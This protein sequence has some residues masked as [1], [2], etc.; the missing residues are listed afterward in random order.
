VSYI[1][2][3]TCT[4]N[5]NQ[6]G[7]GTFSAAPQVQRTITVK[8]SQTITF[9]AL[10]SPR[11]VNQTATL[12]ATASSGLTVTYA[13]TS[14]APAKCSISGTTVTYLRTGTCTIRASQAGD[15]EFEAA[16]N[17]SV[18]VTVQ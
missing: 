5:A 8:R 13:V 10:T 1:A 15:A 9:P 11:N 3:G 14:A 7:D 18:S 16:P 12:A 2:G 4:I 17:V 6:A